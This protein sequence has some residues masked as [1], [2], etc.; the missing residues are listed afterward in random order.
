MKQVAPKVIRFE[1]DVPSF[2][3]VLPYNKGL[4]KERFGA[5]LQE[6]WL[7]ENRAW[8][9]DED[10][11]CRLYTDA[12][13]ICTT[14]KRGAV[15]DFNSIPEVVEGIL[16]RDDRKGFV[17]GLIH[18]AFFAVQTFSFEFSNCIFRQLHRLEGSGRFKSWLKW[19]AVQSRFARKVWN[20]GFP[21]YEKRWYKIEWLDK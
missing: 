10:W 12:G 11:H 17:A 7:N 4:L 19:R 21:D 1:C 2:T 15:T 8:V 16:K 20:A 6:L 9:Y 18:D 13:V 5:D 3:P 14:I